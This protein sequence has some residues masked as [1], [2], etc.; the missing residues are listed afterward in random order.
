M[1]RGFFK[2]LRLVFVWM[3]TVTTSIQHGSCF[4]VNTAACCHLIVPRHFFKEFL[5]RMREIVKCNGTEEKLEKMLEE[6][7]RTRPLQKDRKTIWKQAGG[8]ETLINHYSQA[9]SSVPPPP[10]PKITLL[11]LSFEIKVESVGSCRFQIHLCIF[12][13]VMSREFTRKAVTKF[14]PAGF[15]WIWC[16]CLLWNLTHSKIF[17]LTKYREVLVKLSLLIT[18]AG[19]PIWI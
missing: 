10:P 12:A 19:M 17:N 7:D 6:E 3:S 11:N 1:L 18:H 14:L 15:P 4:K 9:K 8:S 13:C 2:I 16:K 5:S